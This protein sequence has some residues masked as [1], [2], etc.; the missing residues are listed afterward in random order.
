MLGEGRL[1]VWEKRN[2]SSPLVCSG[3]RGGRLPGYHLEGSGRGRCQPSLAP[4]PP[5]LLS[6]Y[7]LAHPQHPPIFLPFSL[8][9][10]PC[11]YP[12]SKT[13]LLPCSPVRKWLLAAPAAAVRT[14][15]AAAK[16]AFLFST[17]PSLPSSAADP[18]PRAGTRRPL[19]EFWPPPLRVGRFTATRARRPG[20]GGL[21]PRCWNAYLIHHVHV[22]QQQ[23]QHCRGRE[24]P[25]SKGG[26]RARRG[27][28]AIVRTA[29]AAAAPP[30]A[31][32][33]HSPREPAHSGSV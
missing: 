11:L 31:P 27:R 32:P 9:I 4:P 8:P 2:R 23:H 18:S 6:L 22:G 21:C 15:L 3:G 24:A 12:S 1:G 20:S 16:G 26:R 7:F 14:A 10:P 29:Q 13:P 33:P 30:L 5:L 19:L 17:S 28:R 25:A